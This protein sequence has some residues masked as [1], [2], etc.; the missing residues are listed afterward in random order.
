MANTLVDIYN[1][2]QN[3]EIKGGV[4]IKAKSQHTIW[5]KG[6]REKMNTKCTYIE[7]NCEEEQNRSVTVTRSMNM[8]P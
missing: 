7:R 4:L 8:T 5:G 6:R 2:T 1:G 3:G